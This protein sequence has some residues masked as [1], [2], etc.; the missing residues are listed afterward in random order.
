MANWKM[1]S[2]LFPIT[3]VFS[4]PLQDSFALLTHYFHATSGCG[5]CV[6]VFKKKN[7]IFQD[8]ILL[9]PSLLSTSLFSLHLAISGILLPQFIAQDATSQPHQLALYGCQHKVLCAQ[10]RKLMPCQLLPVS[11]AKP[12]FFK[13]GPLGF[14]YSEV[15]NAKTCY[16]GLC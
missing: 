8:K 5:Y 13:K 14:M 2:F 6:Y 15:I 11:N 10:R 4:Q 3:V 12:L 16:P 9:S 1:L 7:L